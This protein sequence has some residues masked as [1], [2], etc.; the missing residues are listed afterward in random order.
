MSARGRA[1]VRVVMKGVGGAVA[2]V[3]PARETP[4]ETFTLSAGF[5]PKVLTDASLTLTAAGVANAAVTQR[6]V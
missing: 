6:L 1:R 5:P 2:A 4:G 3:C